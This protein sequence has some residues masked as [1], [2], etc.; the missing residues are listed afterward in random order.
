MDKEQ[1]FDI[2]NL[3]SLIQF[4]KSAIEAWIYAFNSETDNDARRE[5]KINLYECYFNFYINSLAF[6]RLFSEC[7]LRDIPFNREKYMKNI[8]GLASIL[9]NFDDLFKI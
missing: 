6:L 8:N 9:N 2:Q 4:D 5:F 7:Q 3:N 1:L